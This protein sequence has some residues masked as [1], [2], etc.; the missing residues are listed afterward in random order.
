MVKGGLL[1]KDWFLALVFSLL[2][3][4]GVFNGVA[5]LDRFE[6]MAYDLGIKSAHRNPGSN[7]NIAIVAIDDDSIQQIGRWPWPRNVSAEVVDKLSAAKVKVIGLQ[8]PLS[9]PQ[10]DAG[11]GYIRRLSAAL[12]KASRKGEVAALLK[13]AEQELDTDRRL[14]AAI[15]AAGN[16]LLPRKATRLPK[17]SVANV[18]QVV[19]VGKSSLTERVGKLGSRLMAVVDVGLRLLLSL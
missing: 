18:S 8:I 16:V 15:P 7:E 4:I 6:L 3:L 12:G 10:T 9:E 5:F 17:D 14:A 19:T 11:L 2:F 1:K 13:Q